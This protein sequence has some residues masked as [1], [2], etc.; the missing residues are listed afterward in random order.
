M[1]DFSN[2]GQCKAY[3]VVRCFVVCKGNNSLAK[4][5]CKSHMMRACTHSVEKSHTELWRW[6]YCSQLI[7]GLS[8]CGLW[9]P[10]K[11]YEKSY[12]ARLAFQQSNFGT[13]VI[14]VVWEQK[15]RLMWLAGLNPSFN[16]T[17]FW[18]LSLYL[19]P[20]TMRQTQLWDWNKLDFSLQLLNRQKSKQPHMVHGI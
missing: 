20:L 15:L 10:K 6:H 2:V 17:V 3:W 19:P 11:G 4:P 13:I 1:A 7:L 8:H 9:K 16:P 14:P 5:E 12:L 18:I